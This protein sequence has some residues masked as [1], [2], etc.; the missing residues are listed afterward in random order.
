MREII[1]NDIAVTHTNYILQ[2]VPANISHLIQTGEGII[3]DEFRAW[4]ATTSTFTL[5][6]K[7]YNCTVSSC[8]C[9]PSLMYALAHTFLPTPFRKIS[10]SLGLSLFATA[11]LFICTARACPSTESLG[12]L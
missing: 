9:R 8:N 11:P 2:A 4:G 12:G 7:G 1:A 5:S 3:V 10:L 6:T